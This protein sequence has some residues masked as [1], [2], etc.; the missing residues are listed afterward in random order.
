MT[1]KLSY[2]LSTIDTLPIRGEYKVWLYR[3][4]VISLLRFHLS[5]D[6]IRKGANLATRYLKRWLGLPRCA[7]RAILYY[8][9]VCC[10]SLSQVSREAKLSLLFCI[11][12]SGDPQ[13][14]E[15]GPQLHLGDSYLQT[16]DSD[17]S[18]ISKACSQLSSF[19]M[20]CPLYLLSKKLLSA[21]ECSRYDD[22][23]DSL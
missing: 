4:Y 8:P 12:A 1:D 5:V 13:L 14:L 9:G 2:L 17:Y 23:L 21:T 19:P 20:A 18:I 11:S 6:A 16:Q 22:H 7:T 15:L 10:P 3:N